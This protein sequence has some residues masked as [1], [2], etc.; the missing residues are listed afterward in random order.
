MLKVR[1]VDRACFS[2]MVFSGMGLTV[3]TV[4]IKLHVASM[5]ADKQENPT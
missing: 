4:Y 1:E 2:P 3:T 5:L